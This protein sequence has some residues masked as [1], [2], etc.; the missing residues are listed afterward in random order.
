MI[1]QSVE[2]HGI[3]THKNQMTG[4]VKKT[5]KHEAWAR[6]N[7]LLEPEK[8]W[9]MNGN[10]NDTILSKYLKKLKYMLLNQN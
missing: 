2:R 5:D 10:K 9:N 3:A 8:T 6:E 1:Y 7:R 4:A